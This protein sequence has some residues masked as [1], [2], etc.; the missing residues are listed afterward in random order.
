MKLRYTDRA[1]RDL[2]IAFDW[3]EN[4]FPGLGLKFLGCI[5]D[6][7]FLLLMFL[8]YNQ[9]TMDIRIVRQADD[10]FKIYPSLRKVY[11]KLS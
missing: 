11:P 9:R 5:N 1:L 2:E 8:N 7:F 10:F 6:N 3:Y 4:Q